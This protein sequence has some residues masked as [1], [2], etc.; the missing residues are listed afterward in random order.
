MITIIDYKAGNIRSVENAL[1]RLGSPYI[2]TSNPEDVM[3]AEKVIFPG[4]GS[5][6]DAISN[7]N[8]LGLLD[9]IKNCTCPFL[10]I[11]LGMQL[12]YERLE[13]SD[14]PGLGIIQG[15]VK[16]FPSV[17][18]VPHLGWNTLMLNQD[19]VLTKGI[20]ED[21]Y[22]FFIHSYYA[23]ITEYSIGI[24]DYI[25]QFSSVVQ[26]DNFF[27]TQFHPEKSGVAG[28]KVLMNFISIK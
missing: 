1:N 15:T 26:K 9:A 13:E 8:K 7:L 24:T 27:G 20:T 2:V 5:A 11:C 25:L 22:F 10:G 19:S 6:G 16:L 28:E 17:K 3:N 4:V 12:L 18:K 14:V 21:D 23:P